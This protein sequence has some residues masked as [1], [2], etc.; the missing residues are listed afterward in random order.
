MRRNIL[1]DKKDTIP[2]ESNCLF[3]GYISRRVYKIINV[4][5]LSHKKEYL[6]AFKLKLQYIFKNLCFLSLIQITPLT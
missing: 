5:M 6:Q 2:I 1:H 4:H 3:S